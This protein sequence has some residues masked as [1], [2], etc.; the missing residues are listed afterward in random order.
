[1]PLALALGYFLANSR[2]NVSRWT[3]GVATTSF[4]VLAVGQNV[5]LPWYAHHRS[6]IREEEVLRHYCGDRGE[7]VVCYPRP[8]SA[9]AFFLDR[10]DLKN[11]RSKDIE[12]L[13]YLVRTQPRTVILC[14]H[15]HSLEGLRELLPPEVRIVETHH[16]G[17]PPVPVV[18]KRWTERLNHLMGRTALGLSDLAAAEMKPPRRAAG[19]IPAGLA[20]AARFRHHR[21]PTQ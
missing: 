6:P 3:A 7:S 20:P 13:R 9:A 17:L 11:Y 10:T 19:F 12:E 5:L 18:P 15:R 4:V 21:D 8:C 16:F 2:W 1:P 14:T